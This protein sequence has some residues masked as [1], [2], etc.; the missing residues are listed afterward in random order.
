MLRPGT[1]SRLAIAA[2]A[3]LAFGAVAAPFAYVPNEGS[4]SVSVIDTATDRIVSTFKVC[5]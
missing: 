2:A 4:A 1:M 5:V 3:L